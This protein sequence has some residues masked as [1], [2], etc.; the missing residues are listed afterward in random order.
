MP[1]FTEKQMDIIGRVLA[2]YR[3]EI[4]AG[5]RRDL[6]ELAKRADEHQ[7]QL[8]AVTKRIDDLERSRRGAK[9]LDARGVFGKGRAA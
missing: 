5:H 9:I 6:A 1:V 4:E 7:H 8:A 2:R 3:A